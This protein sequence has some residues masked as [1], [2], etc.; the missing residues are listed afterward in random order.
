[1]TMVI[2]LLMIAIDRILNTE[3]EIHSQC[4]KHTHLGFD[5]FEDPQPAATWGSRLTL[6]ARGCVFQSHRT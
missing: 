4:Q 3:R 1:M 5:R 6:F 2:E